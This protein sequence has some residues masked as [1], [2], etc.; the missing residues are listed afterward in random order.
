M[1]PR[2]RIKTDK[3]LCCTRFKIWATTDLYA[4][5]ALVTTEFG[6]PGH[7]CRADHDNQAA[8]WRCYL[9]DALKRIIQQDT[10]P[11]HTLQSKTLTPGAVIWLHG[12]HTTMVQSLHSIAKVCPSLLRTIRSPTSTGLQCI[13]NSCR[14]D[15]HCLLLDW[16]LQTTNECILR[17]CCGLF[18]Y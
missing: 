17:F 9:L 10:Q 18:A 2:Q 13:K 8:C 14:P 16:P 6:A 4:K 15:G 7:V 11:R 5:Q 1:P 12:C 3:T